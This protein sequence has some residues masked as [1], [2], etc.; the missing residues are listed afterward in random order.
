MLLLKVYIIY[1]YIYLNVKVVLND[2]GKTELT[3]VGEWEGGSRQ[4]E[5]SPTGDGS[6]GKSLP[7][8]CNQGP[9][10]AAGWPRLS[11]VQEGDGAVWTQRQGHFKT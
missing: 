5:P 10:W 4:Q 7:P 8:P 1:I 2:F 11:G 9:G 6:Q 3:G